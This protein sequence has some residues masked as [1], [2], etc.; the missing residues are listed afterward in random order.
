MQRSVYLLLS[1]SALSL[2]SCAQRQGEYPSGVVNQRYVHKYGIEV[3]SNDWASRGQSGDVITTLAN[4]ATLKESYSHGVLEG[5]TT[6]TFPHNDVVEKVTVYRQG[7]VEREIYND[8]SGRPLREVKYQSPTH[9]RMTYWYN[10]GS[11]RCKEEYSG[12]LL[13]R[14]E[15]FTP[16]HQLESRV[17]D[18]IGMRVVRDEYGQHLHS[19]DIESGEVAMQTKFYPSGMPHE[20]VEVRNGRPDG[21]KRIYLPS[22]EPKTMETWINGTQDGLTTH[23]QNGVRYSE[24]PYVNG[25]KEGIERIYRNGEHVVQ[26]ISWSKDLRHGATRS[27][28]ENTVVEEWFY[29]DRPVTKQT[30]DQLS[31]GNNPYRT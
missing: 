25:K 19:E 10:D 17:D 18:G 26:E 14:G 29:K 2:G 3:P 5:E 24:V 9:Y 30:F 27:F 22:G 21:V 1:V 28:V 7:E 11:P 12:E 8:P 23:Y 31:R 16:N 15:Y 13:V 4:G 6:Q 20:Q